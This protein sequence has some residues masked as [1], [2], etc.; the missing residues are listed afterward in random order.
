MTADAATT[1]SVV[2][3]FGALVGAAAVILAGLL[4]RQTSDKQ[5]KEQRELFERQLMAQR[6]KSDGQL[7][8]AYEQL[9]LLREG[10]ITER[11]MRA[12]ENLGSSNTHVRI[13][14]SGEKP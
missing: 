9:E 10:Q 14:A 7:K 12:I 8:S 4:Q 13:G 5:L 2:A 11:F 1:A 3:V 6:E